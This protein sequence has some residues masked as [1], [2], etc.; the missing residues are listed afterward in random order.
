ML[1]S[2]AA[3]HLFG[4]PAEEGKKSGVGVYLFRGEFPVKPGELDLV[5]L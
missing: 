5:C 3:V 2:A 4:E 1:F